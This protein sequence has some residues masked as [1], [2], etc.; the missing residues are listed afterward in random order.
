MDPSALGICLIIALIFVVASFFVANQIISLTIFFVGIFFFALGLFGGC[1][2]KKA[3]SIIV[4]EKDIGH[5]W[6]IYIYA[7]E[8]HTISFDKLGKIGAN[9]VIVDG[10]LHNAT[11]TQFSLRLCAP[12]SNGFTK[13]AN[14]NDVPVVVKPA[15][16][17]AAQEWIEYYNNTAAAGTDP[18]VVFSYN[19]SLGKF[20]F[21]ITAPAASDF[22][23]CI[24]YEP[25]C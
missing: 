25:H 12:S 6:P 13:D 20:M 14:G 7:G 10:N 22:E 16:A 17:E 2:R 4:A 15:S 19:E 11:D 3:S 18:I 21:T 1:S 9:V 24:R 23:G 5:N 8:T